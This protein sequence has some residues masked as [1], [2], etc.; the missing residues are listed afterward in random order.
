MTRRCR[1]FAAG[2]VVLLAA[3]CGPSDPYAP[4]KGG[5]RLGQSPTGRRVALVPGELPGRIPSVAPPPSSGAHSPQALLARASGLYGHWTSGTA[6]AQMRRLAKLSVGQPRAEFLQLAAQTRADPQAKNVRSRSQPLSIMVHGR[7]TR[8][9]AEIVT[10]DSITG[11]GI[12]D[13]PSV[14]VVL[15]TVVRHTNGWAIARWAPQP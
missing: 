9:A 10:R 13:S 4:S 11:P 5:A 2:A 15:A 1:S 3:G 7:G 12:T 6:P 8:R 14:R